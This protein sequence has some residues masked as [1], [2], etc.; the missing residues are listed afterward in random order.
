MHP[1]HL[2]PVA[3]AVAAML[4]PATTA[5]ATMVINGGLTYADNN[6]FGATFIGA[7]YNWSG[8]SKNSDNRATMVSPSYFLTAKHYAP[9]VGSTVTFQGSNG[10]DYSYTVASLVTLTTVIG[11]TTYNSDLALGK[12]ATPVNA[13]ISQYAVPIPGAVFFNDPLFM[14]GSGNYAGKNAVD[15]VEIV[16]G[17][18]VYGVS[19]IMYYDNF[20]DEGFLQ[21][22]DSSSP[23]FV[24]R[25]GQLAMVGTHW[26]IGG[27]DSNWPTSTGPYGSYYSVDTY[28]PFYIDQINS[29]MTGGEQ[30]TVLV[31]EPAGLLLGA[32]LLLVGLRRRHGRHAGRS[33]TV[34]N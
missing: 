11:S 18:G 10:T 21:A 17:S 32:T 28:V 2:K 7:D 13:F 24:V 9:G 31:P 3:C 1:S 14:Y 27:P 34:K 5:F 12:L 26:A 19:L 23:S 6:R 30:L 15:G 16:S 29:L 33:G 8:V 25:N 20:P 4:L 22:G